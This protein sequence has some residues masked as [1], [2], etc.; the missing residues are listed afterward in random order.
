ML[1]YEIMGRK[2]FSSRNISVL[3]N[4]YHYDYLCISFTLYHL[5]DKKMSS[6]DQTLNFFCPIM[7]M[8]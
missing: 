8:L 1:V 2:P 4:K 3:E 7:H 6:S 5:E